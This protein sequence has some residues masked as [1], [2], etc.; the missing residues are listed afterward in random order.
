MRNILL[1]KLTSDI[2]TLLLLFIFSKALVQVFL[3]GHEK[4]PK[5]SALTHPILEGRTLTS[6]V[7]ADTA[8]NMR[9]PIRFLALVPCRPVKRHQL[10]PFQAQ[11]SPVSTTPSLAI[12]VERRETA[13]ATD[14]RPSNLVEHVL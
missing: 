4:L 13:L 12:A 9:P 14:S 6:S 11:T 5:V 3:S 10:V 2:W 8:S 7:E 1:S